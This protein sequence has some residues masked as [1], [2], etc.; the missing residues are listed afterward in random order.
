MDARAASEPGPA[1][2]DTSLRLQLRPAAA[3]DLDAINAV[4]ERAVMTWKLPERVKR[5]ALPT[6]RYDAFDLKHL[7]V[8]V[9]EDEAAGI[10]GVVA[11]DEAAER[12]CPPDRRGLLVH[13]IYVDPA[14]QRGGLGG[15]LLA[16][17]EAAARGLGCDGLLV[18]AQADAVGF[19]EAR[20]LVRLPVVDADRDYPHRFWFGL[21]AER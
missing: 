1:P 21:P 10:V 14:W 7:R 12:D 20:G 5:L 8:T 13:G 11:C 4:I 6:Y 17:A 2:R 19:F 18:K 15:R 16:A 3:G 9:A